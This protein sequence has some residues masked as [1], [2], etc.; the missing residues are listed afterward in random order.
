MSGFIWEH[1]IHV[2]VIWCSRKKTK[3]HKA[4]YWQC[5][6]VIPWSWSGNVNTCKTTCSGVIVRS[7]N[8]Q[9]NIQ[10][11]D[12]ER[13]SRSCSMAVLGPKVTIT[14]MNPYFMVTRRWKCKQPETVQTIKIF[15]GFSQNDATVICYAYMSLITHFCAS[16][17]T[18]S[19]SLVL[20]CPVYRHLVME[21]RRQLGIS[22]GMQAL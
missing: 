22:H 6:N 9:K 7:S 19:Y 21:L 5:S 4:H 14:L 2:T 11:T 3:Q 17:C 18:V 8:W 12:K 1:L 20:Y 13:W 16:W 15:S 10:K